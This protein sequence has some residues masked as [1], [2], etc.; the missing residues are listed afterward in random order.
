MN[1]IYL[2]AYILCLQNFHNTLKQSIP[3]FSLYLLFNL[4]PT[5]SAQEVLIKLN[6]Q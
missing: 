2:Q 1:R 5:Q 6:A 4:Y 3:L